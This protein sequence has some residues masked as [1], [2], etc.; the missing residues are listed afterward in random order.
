MTRR[1]FFSIVSAVATG[2]LVVVKGYGQ[3]PR[4]ASSSPDA[5]ASASQKCGMPDATDAD[6]KYKKGDVVEIVFGHPLWTHENGLIDI[7]PD[8]VG[9][10]AVVMNINKSDDMDLYIHEC[11]RAAWFSPWQ[12]KL[13]MIPFKEPA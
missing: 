8:L 1:H 5:E 3:K 10:T 12:V 6:V 4:T 9:K 7:R 13:I 2:I 11:G